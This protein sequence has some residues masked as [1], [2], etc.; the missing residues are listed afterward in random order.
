[1]VQVNL[2]T[3]QKWTH[4]HRKQTLRNRHEK[5]TYGSQRGKGGKGSF[6]D[7]GLTNTHCYLLP[8]FLANCHLHGPPRHF[9]VFCLPY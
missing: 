7:L 4:R 8:P 3:K 2:F 6:G 9:P 1:M 5:Q